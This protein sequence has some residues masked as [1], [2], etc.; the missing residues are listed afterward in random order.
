[1]SN[2]FNVKINCVVFSTNINLNKRYLLSLDSNQIILPSFGLLSEHLENT[3]Y[4]IIEFL[5][6]F[7]FVNELELLP[8]LI[9]INSKSL[10]DNENDLTIVSG[11]IIIHTNSI[12]NSH[13]LEFEFLK[14]QKYSSML[15]EVM[16]K[17]R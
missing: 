8:Q 5:K 9:N 3:E 6:Q 14:E 11:F 13:W 15:F 2:M 17:L 16:Q 10:S 12:N 1:M 4:K 7:V